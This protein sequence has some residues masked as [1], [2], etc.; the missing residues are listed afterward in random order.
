MRR[1]SSEGRWWQADG[2]YVPSAAS[3]LSLEVWCLTS[4]LSYRW[5]GRPLRAPRGFPLPLFTAGNFES[6]WIGFMLYWWEGTVHWSGPLHSKKYGLLMVITLPQTLAHGASQGSYSGITPQLHGTPLPSQDWISVDSG[7]GRA[8]PATTLRGKRWLCWWRSGYGYQALLSWLECGPILCQPSGVWLN[9]AAARPILTWWP[10]SW[11]WMRSSACTPSA[12]QCTSQVSQTSCQMICPECGPLNRMHS[13]PSYTGFPRSS[14]PSE[15][16]ASGGP[17][18]SPIGEEQRGR[19]GTET[20]EAH[21]RQRQLMALQSPRTATSMQ[22]WL[23]VII[24]ATL[25]AEWTYGKR[26]KAAE[27]MPPRHSRLLPERVTAGARFAPP[28][29]GELCSHP[30]PIAGAVMLPCHSGP[31]PVRVRPARSI[32]PLDDGPAIPSA[33]FSRPGVALE[34]Q[35]GVDGL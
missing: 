28:L 5:C 26:P 35:V 30:H 4:D 23:F 21:H 24:W 9:C 31:Q 10:V 7:Q 33:T 19:Q 34:D 17:Q 2:Q 32:P 14:R 22:I 1:C 29:A 12:W 16:G 15:T 27:C 6:L 11:L 8:T 3:C 25:V 20:V 13:R 18:Q